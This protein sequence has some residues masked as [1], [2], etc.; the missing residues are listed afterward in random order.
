M[1]R[2]RLD[3]A[4]SLRNRLGRREIWAGSVAA[5]LAVTGALAF[6]PLVRAAVGAEAARRHVV[7]EVGAVRPAWFGVRL[8]RVV[9]H[10][11]GV[12]SVQVRLD[13]LRLRFTLG[14]HVGWIRVDGATV[15]LEGSELALREQLD[16][17]ANRRTA[18][19]SSKHESP[20]VEL[21]GLSVLWDDGDSRGPRVDLR[22]VSGTYGPEQVS[23]RVSDARGLVGRAAISLSDGVIELGPSRTLKRA[24]ASRAVVEWTSNEAPAPAD[25][26]DPATP[27]VH[28]PNLRL[29]GTMAVSAASLLGERVPEDADVGIDALTWKITRDRARVAFTVGPAPLSL[30][31]SASRFELRFATDSAA[32]STAL[33]VRAALPT[34]RG[35]AVLTLEGGPVSLSLLGIREGAAGL[36]DVAHATMTGRA[37]IVLA[38]D[39]SA[40]TFDAEG[41]T[42][43]LSVQD[44]RLAPDVVHGIDLHL[45]A[46]GALSATGELRVDDFD[47]GLGAIHLVAAGVLDEEPDHVAAA[48][49]FEAPGAACQALLDSVPTA[50]L[51]TLRGMR[52]GGTIG[53]RGRFAFDT[54]SLDNLDLDYAVDDRCRITQVPPVLARQR[55]DQPFEH[56]VYLPDGSV[57]QQTTGPGTPNWT[58]LDEVSPY[59]QVAVLTT[60]DGA[61]PKHHGFNHPSIRASIIANLKARRFVRGAS[62]IT[63]QL[64]KNLFLSRDKTLSRKLEEVVLT[65]YLEQAFSKDELMEL[66]LNV[67]EFGPAVYGITAAAEYYFGRTPAELDIA[68]CLFLASVLPSPLRYG[69]MR[70]GGDAPERWM[71]TLR[72]L[73]QIA[74]KTGR[75]SDTELAEA[76]KEPLV[77]WR[78][79]ERPPPRPPVRVRPRLDGEIDD[80]N[81]APAPD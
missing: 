43:G 61:F 22:D 79:G 9:A 32:A 53:A 70:D 76:E 67:I 41:G 29:A 78:G 16:R 75:I 27:L 57:D 34:D 31:R 65:E 26:E 1:W 81:T 74:H 42:R 17:W 62:T 15:H 51:P 2:L 44:A 56:S 48:F 73:M 12:D 55:F 37:R 46:R 28:L 24:R 58:P 3:V 14:L 45:R 35:D 54:R 6:G 36:V 66:Y 19:A 33:A 38:A 77:F 8:L 39:G 30:T 5:V 10:P 59:M 47:A 40:L 69:A 80:V 72:T 25:A 13:G 52:I 23:L 7:V 20:V 60:E 49:R 64:A 63:M 11:E 50:L 4:R 18:T 68:E 71:R 21:A